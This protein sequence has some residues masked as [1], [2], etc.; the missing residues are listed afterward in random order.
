M[1]LEGSGAYCGWDKGRIELLTGSGQRHA[2]RGVGA[3]DA[4]GGHR[5]VWN[6]F[7]RS[8]LVPQRGLEPG[9][10]NPKQAPLLAVFLT[11]R[12]SGR[13][14]TSKGQN[15]ARECASREYSVAKPTSQTGSSWKFASRKLALTPS[16]GFDTILRSWNTEFV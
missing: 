2:T 12:L 15:H 4:V 16:A 9:R 10:T 8:R 6:T 14:S 3:G 11:A 5:R 1:S 13:P 7:N